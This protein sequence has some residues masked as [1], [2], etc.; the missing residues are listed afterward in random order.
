MH[1]CACT[2]KCMC[3]CRTRIGSPGTGG[4]TGVHEPDVNP[5]NQTQVFRK[6]MLLTTEPPLLIHVISVLD[7][8][9]FIAFHGNSLHIAVYACRYTQ[10]MVH[11]DRRQVR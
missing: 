4:V 7:I 1:G 10:F 11:V 3:A 2:Y 5:G 6:I 8:Q 9:K